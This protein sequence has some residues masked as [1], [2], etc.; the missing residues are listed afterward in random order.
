MFSW[1]VS[2]SWWTHLHNFINLCDLNLKTL[3]RKQ[4]F[5]PCCRPGAGLSSPS[6]TVAAEH[7]SAALG[8]T[9]PPYSCRGGSWG[10]CG[11]SRRLPGGIKCNWA[12]RR[13]SSPSDLVHE[14]RKSQISESCQR[15]RAFC[16]PPL[17][18]LSQFISP[19]SPA[20]V[21]VA[22]LHIS[23]G[24]CGVSSRP[25]T[26]ES[27]VP[28]LS[29]KR[30]SAVVFGWIKTSRHHSMAHDSWSLNYTDFW[31]HNV[32]ENYNNS[33]FFSRGNY[34][35]INSLIYLF[36]VQKIVDMVRLP[37]F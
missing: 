21:H 8:P 34:S 16:L 9:R 4:V 30:K 1:Q 24:W 28:P 27:L 2:F 10:H 31:G 36:F 17:L 7:W 35:E 20:G 22:E 26:A 11:R 23:T 37:C 32:S 3:F 15:M 25:Q 18:I 13:L 12:W 33:P 29:L 5:P 19:R 14:E 6:Q